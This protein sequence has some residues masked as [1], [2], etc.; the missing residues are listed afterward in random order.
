MIDIELKLVTDS[1][2]NLIKNKDYIIWVGS[3]L[4][5]LIGYY[6][7][8]ELIKELCKVFKIEYLTE[9]EEQSEKAG[10][11]F[12]EKAE[13]CKNIDRFLFYKFIND[14]YANEKIFTRNAYTLLAKL[15]FKAYITT[16]YDPLIKKSCSLEN[17]RYVF[18]YPNLNIHMIERGVSP[19]YYIHGLANNNCGMSENKLILA[20]SDFDE[21]YSNYGRSFLEM[22]FP[23]QK[24]LFVGCRLGEPAFI[25]TF[26]RSKKFIEDNSRNTEWPKSDKYILLPHIIRE[27]DE[28]LTKEFVEEQKEDEK[29]KELGIKV[30]R[31]KSTEDH[32]EIDE[33]LLEIYERIF[34]IPVTIL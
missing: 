12:M 13:E 5:K 24:I 16:N 32:K 17:K 30:L 1:L 18:V 20:R 14:H 19:I 10:E 22:L 27:K 3:G 25:E 4:S 21:A 11:F 33:M 9:N 29:Y 28:N 31:Y 2:F 26:K 23:F 6:E 7:W 8:K 34:P 15:P